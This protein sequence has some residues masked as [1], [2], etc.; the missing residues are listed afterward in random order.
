MINGVHHVSFKCSGEQSRRVI[1]FY[2]DTLGEQIE[3]SMISKQNSRRPAIKRSAA[4]L[5]SAVD[6][7]YTGSVAVG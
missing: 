3:F 6:F 4:L 2:S 1:A 7:G 5:Y